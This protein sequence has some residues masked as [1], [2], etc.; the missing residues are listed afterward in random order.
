MSTPPLGGPSNGHL[1]PGHEMGISLEIETHRSDSDSP[2]P[3][4][5][6]SNRSSPSPSDDANDIS[7]HIDNDVQMSESDNASQDNASDDGDFDMEESI[8]SQHEDAEE[9]R[10]SSTDSNRV[11][12]R[13]AA[14]REDEY[15]K[16]NPELYGLRRSVRLEKFSPAVRSC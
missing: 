1:S 7:N 6:P 14:V 2:E 5:Y 11:P 3:H 4:N 10:A 12:K 9:E 16:A 13:K 15:M 8:P